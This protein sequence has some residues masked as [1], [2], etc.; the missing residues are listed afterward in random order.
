MQYLVRHWL[1]YSNCLVEIFTQV[2][3]ILHPISS[4]RTDKGAKDEVKV[5]HDQF[6]VG[7]LIWSRNYQKDVKWLPGKITRQYGPKNYQVQTGDQ[8]HKHNID[9]LRGRPAK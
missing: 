9:Q 5:C 8:T 1:N 2:R 7:D 6:K 3:F 4:D